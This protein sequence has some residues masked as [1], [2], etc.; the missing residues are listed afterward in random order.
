MNNAENIKKEALQDISLA[1]TLVGLEA[2][3]ARYLGKKGALSELLKGL[4]KYSP[5]EKKALGLE[6][7]LAKGALETA[8]NQKKAEL[9]KAELN[10]KLKA[11][12]VDYSEA[13]YFPF[14]KGS[15]HPLTQTLKE[16]TDIFTSMGFSVAEGPEIETDWYNF[17]ALN[18]PADHPARDT[19]DTF[20]L[21]GGKN[22]LR[23]HTS[24]VQVR[25]MEGKAPPVNIIAPGR[26]YR[27]EAADTSHSAIFHQIEGLSVDKNV[28]F[29]DLKNTLSVFINNLFGASTPIR[30]RPS[31]FQF[32]EPS[33]EVD[34]QCFLCKGSGCRTCKNSGWIELLGC[35]MVH[36][37]VF[38]AVNYDSKEYTGFAFGIG[39]DRVAMLKYGIDDIR[40][41]YENDLRFLKQF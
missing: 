40:L 31:H 19:Q 14:Q 12:K 24:P 2:V 26:V 20:Y 33:A 17:E 16:M 6:L 36:P 7:N 23:T 41:L 22:L 10:A 39:V 32:T 38:K 5:D 4:S 34:A 18:I 3:H 35:G 9:S 30:F 21:E 13:F 27:N 11:E 15:S 25:I 8:I 28:T 1:Q 29:A 37:N